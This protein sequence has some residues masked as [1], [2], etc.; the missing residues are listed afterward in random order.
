MLI[1]ARG[2]KYLEESEIDAHQFYSQIVIVWTKNE[3]VET[4]NTIVP[5]RKTKN[6]EQ[7]IFNFSFSSVFVSHCAF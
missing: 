6:K 1:S 3:L 2:E 4:A 5:T 7:M